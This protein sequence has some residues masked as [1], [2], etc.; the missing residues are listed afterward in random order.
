MKYL[1]LL[2]IISILFSCG[3]GNDETNN[4]DDTTFVVDS[5]TS[6]QVD[7]KD[8][9]MNTDL[10]NHEF[11]I[12]MAA[13]NKDLS[14]SLNIYLTLISKEINSE[15]Q[16]VKA[17]DIREKI[18]PMIEEASFH[19]L[20]GLQEDYNDVM[21]SA[22][23]KAGFQGVYAEGMFQMLEI[24]PILEKEIEQ[25]CSEKFKLR[26]KFLNAYASS[27]GSEYPFDSMGDE[28]EVVKIGEEIMNKYPNS[29]LF[30]EIKEKYMWEVLNFTDFHTVTNPDGEYINYIVG[31]LDTEF[32]PT[33]SDRSNFENFVKSLPSSRYTPVIKK[34]LE[35]TSDV[36]PKEG[37]MV[38]LV[39]V[40][41]VDDYLKADEKIF[42]LLN[43]GIDIPH[44]IIIRDG[45]EIQSAVVYRFY[46]D[47]KKAEKALSVIQTDY[48]NARIITVDRGGNKK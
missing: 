28:M 25:Y 42:N 44:N 22:L 39:T 43:M 37:A 3:N 27:L 33:G 18:L 6:E 19:Y 5:I 29:K 14:D 16:I 45:D 32:Y 12:K 41:V 38:Y 8:E 20:E 15:A 26:I 36:S 17:F 11:L 34:L 35:N 23:N 40:E 46:S 47:L 48:P 13:Y 4:N 10:S 24:A 21:E 9:G 2:I 1:Y 30:N 31:G 7:L